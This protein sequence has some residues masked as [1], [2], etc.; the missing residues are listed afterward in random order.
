MK[1]ALEQ[2]LHLAWGGL[3]L[4]PVLLW[5][6]PLG[7]AASGIALALPR[8]LVDQWPINRPLDT[9]LDLAMFGLGGAV[10]GL[11]LA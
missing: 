11:V 7:G 1:K 5:P 10:A 8:E 3:A 2:L 4:V 6:G 9:L